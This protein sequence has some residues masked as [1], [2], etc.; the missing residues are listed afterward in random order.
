MNSTSRSLAVI[1]VLLFE[2]LLLALINLGYHQ[3]YSQAFHYGV[4]GQSVL[5]SSGLILGLTVAAVLS[6]RFVVGEVERE[7]KAQAE[8]VHLKNLEE[9]MNVMRSQRHNFNHLCQTLYGLME[10]GAWE[11]ARKMLEQEL[12]EVA[13][14][15]QL[16]RT[17]HPAV[18]AL[19]QK[20]LGI[21]QAQ[22]ISTE[23][24]AKADLA[25]LPLRATEVAGVLGNLL[26]NAI[27]ASVELP[28]E[29]RAVRVELGQKGNRYVLQV[30]NRYRP[31]DTQVM[32]RMFDSDFSTKGAGRGIGLYNVRSIVARYGGQVYPA[33]RE[34]WVV[35]TVELPGKAEAGEAER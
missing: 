29:E 13:V 22:G 15:S 24:E 33:Y 19:L 4:L 16:V 25:Q 28:R 6:V 8:L 9:L 5:L 12:E 14:T 27:E 21:A 11:E 32:A 18:S 26:D 20:K 31:L 1:I 10:V 23:V 7:T 34:G 17:G 30:A 35:M 2:M 3:A